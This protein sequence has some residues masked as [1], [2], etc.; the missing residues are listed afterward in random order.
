MLL[1]LNTG[2]QNGLN[3]TKEEIDTISEFADP[4][5]VPSN[6]LGVRGL[7]NL[8][9]TC[10]MSVALQALVHN[11]FLM[12]YFLN[13]QHSLSTCPLSKVKKF[14]LG[15]EMDYLFASMYNGENEPLSPHHFVSFLQIF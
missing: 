15:C 12:K 1:I 13:D 7:N 9:N 5:E 3:L 11:P 8:G 10:F 6:L 14:C 2:Q 4:C